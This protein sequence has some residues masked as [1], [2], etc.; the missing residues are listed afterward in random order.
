MLVNEE[1]LNLPLRLRVLQWSFAVAFLVLATAFWY[2]QIARH[3]QFL[4]MAENNHQRALPLAAPR[5]VLFDRG[6][7]VLVENRFA[8]NISIVREQTN[9]LE[10][11]AHAVA[12]LTGASV[13]AILEALDRNKRLPAYR[14][15]V[16]LRDATEAQ[17]A[18]VAAHRLELPGVIVEKVPTRR[19]PTNSMAA[20]LIGYVGE[21]TDAQLARPE[22]KDVQGGAIVG[23][24]GVEQTYNPLLMGADGARHVIVNSRG[25]EIDV[26]GE[27]DPIE[28]RRLQLT[29]DGDV[30]RAAE[31]AFR[32]YGFR[33][34]AIALAPSSGEV[35]ALSSLPA[36]DPNAFAA[37]IGREEWNGLLTDPLRPL[38][39]RAIQGRYSPG[40]TFKIAV[41]VAG[42]EEGVVT[43][44]TRVFCSGGATFYGR[45]FKCHKAGG[46]GSVAMREAL[47]KSCNVYF[48]TLGNMLGVDRIHKWATALG[49]GE[50]S[51]VDLPHETRGIMPSTAW[52]KQR[53]GEKWYAGE[54]ISVSIGQGQVSVTP[55]S[56]AVM[57]ASVANGGTRIVP[58]MVRAIDNGK[59]WEQLPPPEGQKDLGLSHVDVV[60]EGLWMVVNGAG[61]GG[62]GR[63]VGYDVGG[64][65]G[66][67]QVISNQGKARAR[68][69]RDLRDHGWFVFFAPAKNPTIAGVVFAE[70]AEHGYFAAPIAK[71]M[72]ETWFAKQEG[73]PLPTLPPL[74]GT[75]VPP[76]VPLPAEV[77]AAQHRAP[78]TPV[79]PTPGGVEP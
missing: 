26:L 69:D 72:M 67:A 78:S 63:I 20:H 30:Q 68:G 58:H 64:K 77:V 42:L 18:S 54:T 36:Y 7:T 28:G 40:S 3:Q 50:M 24:A 44:E 71:Y 79:T 8:F 48:Y 38:N 46:H 52:K 75:P 27:E 47:E 12:Q 45:Y 15:I 25:R 60:R 5:G 59:G 70:H 6:G 4:E 17:I 2:F 13:E 10:R 61:T 11:T 65:T 21:V 53:T 23:Q 41:A 57:M 66:T 1:R 73:R 37:G 29:I 39:N 16:V 19:Y 31:E 35:L 9:D 43:P 62:R 34:A 55:I 49:L 51:G 32:H 74:P 22:Y 33:G 76:G 14:P 56:L